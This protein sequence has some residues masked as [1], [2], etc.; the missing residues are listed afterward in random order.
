MIEGVK[1]YGLEPKS[2]EKCFD[3][4]WTSKVSNIETHTPSPFDHN[5]LDLIS[6]F[7]CVI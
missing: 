5:S 6:I 4:L 7:D 1:M 3:I 2:R